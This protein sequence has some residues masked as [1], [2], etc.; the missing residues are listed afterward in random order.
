MSK[1]KD[2]SQ[3]E[4]ELFQIMNKIKDYVKVDK[5]VL[6]TIA[7]LINTTD[8]L[9]VFKE[10]IESKTENGVL[11]TTEAEITNVVSRIGRRRKSWFI[12]LGQKFKRII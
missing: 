10:W 9:Q 1:I 5:E 12:R 2:Y 3:E 8:K 4:S 6:M 7:V 11:K